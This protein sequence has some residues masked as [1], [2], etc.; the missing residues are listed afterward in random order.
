VIDVENTIKTAI[1]YVLKDE[2]LSKAGQVRRAEGIKALGRFYI[3][4]AESTGDIQARYLEAMK[5]TATGEGMP[6]GMGG[7][8]EGDPGAWGEDEE[9]GATPPPPVEG[10]IPVRPQTQQHKH[11][12]C[13]TQQCT[14]CSH[15]SAT[16]HALCH[17]HTQQWQLWLWLWLWLSDSHTSSTACVR[18][19]CVC[20]HPS[21]IVHHLSS[22]ICVSIIHHLC[23]YHH[24]L[25]SDRC[26]GA[27]Q[28]PGQCRPAQRQARCRP[29]L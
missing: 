5:Q 21:S 12:G 14:A 9:G 8:G 25:S 16:A 7:D 19:M 26:V 17:A 27:S 3:A 24:S 29:W 22:I 4:A 6:F 20:H 10:G 15:S 23:L 28:W 13:S 2:A 1:D 11:I 18:R